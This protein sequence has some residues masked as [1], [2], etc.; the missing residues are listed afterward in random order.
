MNNRSPKN[1]HRRPGLNCSVQA[2]KCRC[3]KMQDKGFDCW[4]R[5]DRRCS[6][7]SFSYLASLPSCLASP[8]RISQRVGEDKRRNAAW[9]Q[10]LPQKVTCRRVFRDRFSA[11]ALLALKR[12]PE[13]DLALCYRRSSSRFSFL[14]RGYAWPLACSIEQMLLR[15]LCTR[16]MHFL[17]W[18]G[19]ATVRDWELDVLFNKQN[20]VTD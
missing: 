10:V 12:I 9:L 20:F 15:F 4:D 1:S 2:A 17:H 16:P 7:S 13:Q 11:R 3:R 14:G 6:W 19:D 5:G 8:L 18:I